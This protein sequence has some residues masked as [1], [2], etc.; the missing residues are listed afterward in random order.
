MLWSF[1]GAKGGVGTSVIA[2]AVAL[3]LA[4]AT[5]VLIV[6]LA[7]DQGDLLGVAEESRPGVWDWLT[8]E[9]VDVDALDRLILD[10]ADRI[11]LL[12]GGAMTGRPPNP[13]RVAALAAAMERRD[14]AVVLDLGVMGADPMSPAAL[15]M[16]ASTNRSIV[17][18]AC[19][20]ALRR[21]QR[22]PVSQFDVVEV[23]EGGRALSTIDIEAILG[24]PVAAR[25]DL[26]PA[27]ARVADAGLLQAR[28]PRR[29]R[30]LAA[31]LVR[32]SASIE[33]A[34]R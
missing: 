9:D 16:A 22:L 27:V 11:C 30:R 21:M 18:R 13:D 34:A 33:R 15:L 14:G 25:V 5:D 20:L 31:E 17:V 12:P 8:A 3:E 6:D 28:M 1:A 2:A 24:R 4:R 7:G 32:E 29:L 10:V 23:R 19:Y 26:D